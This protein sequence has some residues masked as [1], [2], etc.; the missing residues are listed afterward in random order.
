FAAQRR[1]AYWLVTGGGAAG[2]GG[3][4]VGPGAGGGGRAGG[5]GGA[6]PRQRRGATGRGARLWMAQLAGRGAATRVETTAAPSGTGGG[7]SGVARDDGVEPAGRFVELPRQ[8]AILAAVAGT[9]RD[10]AFQVNIHALGCP[11]L[12]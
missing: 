6:A 1:L 9:L 4:P 10:Q 7:T 8:P 12:G 3:A 2:R 11:V 5:R